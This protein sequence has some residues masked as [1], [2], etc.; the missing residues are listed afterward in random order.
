MQRI[1]AVGLVAF[2]LGCRGSSD[3]GPT[4]PSG[5]SFVGIYALAANATNFVVLQQPNYKFEMTGGTF[6]IA[7]DFTWTFQINFQLTNG[8]QISKPVWIEHGTYVIE[9][10]SPTFADNTGVCCVS[11]IQTNNQMLVLESLPP[12]VARAPDGSA[13][14]I[15]AIFQK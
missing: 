6:T 4:M 1:I 7:P 15:A 9:D 11:L 5:S 3:S 8:T 14:E 13:Y 12:A 2:A 10:G